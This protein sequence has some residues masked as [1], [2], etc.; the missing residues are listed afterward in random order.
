MKRVIIL[1]F[2]GLLFAASA[3]W[4]KDSVRVA[5]PYK[6]EDF[7]CT[8]KP[9]GRLFNNEFEHFGYGKFRIC[10]DLNFDGKQDV[11]LLR[12][13]RNDG[14][15]CG[16]AGCDVSIYLQQS[17]GSYLKKEFLLHPLAVNL[18]KIKTG[19]GKLSIYWHMSANHGSLVAYK[20]TSNVISSI[21]TKTVYPKESKHD[22]E[23]YESLFGDTSRL[24]A[25]FARCKNGVIEWSDSY[26]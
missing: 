20:V 17:D 8:G 9:D 16:N 25:E 18:K 26:R 24:K 22:E 7:A 6:E 14:G 15:G 2:L 19:E 4:A 5:D 23:L 21:N 10:T 12:S 11:I 3:G 13:E 1:L